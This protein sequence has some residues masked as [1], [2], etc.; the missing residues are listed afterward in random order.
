MSK[1]LNGVKV[2]ALV[3]DGTDR[4]ELSVTQDALVAAGATVVVVSPQE[5][6]VTR[7]PEPTCTSQGR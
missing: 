2:A 7:R 4:S 5:H 1:P 3:T 6:W